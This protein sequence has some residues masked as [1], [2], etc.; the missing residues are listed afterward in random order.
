[1]NDERFTQQLLNYGLSPDLTELEN[2][3]VKFA[4]SEKK[5]L[6]LNGG[7][8]KGKTFGAMIFLLEYIKPENGPMQAIVFFADARSAEK[9]CMF[10]NDCQAFKAATITVQGSFNINDK[11]HVL[12]TT[13]I[14]LF[15]YFHDLDLTAFQ[16]KA[17]IVDDC[18]E[19]TKKN[20]IKEKL[21]QYLSGI[22][23]TEGKY[24]LTFKEDSSGDYCG[25][26]DLVPEE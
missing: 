7:K 9:C 13:P 11:P 24:I 12:L 3:A 4:S 8:D 26:K 18:D 1:M 22:K 23:N 20:N 6:V 19:L 17:I 2:E 14:S 21:S 16:F 5:L 15:G 10:L 25:L